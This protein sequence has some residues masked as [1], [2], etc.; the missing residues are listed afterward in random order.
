MVSFADVAIS[1]LTTYVSLKLK[2]LLQLTSKICQMLPPKIMFVNGSKKLNVFKSARNY[3][4]PNLGNHKKSFIMDLNCE[5]NI[6][7]ELG[8]TSVAGRKFT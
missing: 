1:L 5:E 3:P 7:L 2:I 4:L 6:Q 8:K